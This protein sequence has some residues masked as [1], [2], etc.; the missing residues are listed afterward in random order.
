M[1]FT[2]SRQAGFQAVDVGYEIN[3]Q[4]EMVY[5]VYFSKVNSIASF[6]QH[7][8]SSDVGGRVARDSSWTIGNPNL[9]SLW[10]TTEL[11]KAYMRVSIK[12]PIENGLG[13]YTLSFLN[14]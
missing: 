7:R 4:F 1:T 2:D 10:T 3:G 12:Y 14:G 11:K 6:T 9:Y 5:Q 8:I 13:Q